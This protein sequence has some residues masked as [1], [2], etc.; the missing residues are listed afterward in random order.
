VPLELVPP[1]TLVGVR[2]TEAMLVAALAESGQ[3]TEIIRR[4]VKIVVTNIDPSC[5][6]ISPS[7]LFSSLFK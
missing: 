3:D 6:H 2:D 1:T 5:F 7:L 4:T